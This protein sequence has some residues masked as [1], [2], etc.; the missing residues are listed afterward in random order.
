MKSPLYSTTEFT[1]RVK[2][3]V[4]G[5]E[6]EF[7][8]QL[9]PLVV[10]QNVTLD[11]EE[12]QRIDA[13]GVAALI[14]L[15]CDACKSGYRFAIVNPSPRVNEILHMVGLDAILVSQNTEEVFCFRLQETAA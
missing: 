4:R 5:R 6:E 15:Y 9:R 3:L 7:L 12:M 1:G 10:R 13:A 2:E 14:A 11:L 8:A